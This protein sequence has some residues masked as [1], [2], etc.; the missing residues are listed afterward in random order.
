[1][2]PKGQ[3][4]GS[5]KARKQQLVADAVVV[6][7]PAARSAK[8]VKTVRTEAPASIS[9][10]SFSWSHLLLVIA[11]NAV[12]MSVTLWSHYH[13]PTPRTMTVSSM[14]SPAHFSEVAAL[15]HISVLSDKIGYRIVGTKQHVEAE[16]WLES[17]VKQYEGWHRTAVDG[18]A[19]VD[20]RGDTQVEVWTQIGDGSHR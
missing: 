15:D 8:P 5:K 4:N 10:A 19:T 3:A 9:G 20:P 6:D 14:T 11:F 7:T 2:A 16:E 18:N 1:M 17:I 13:L 12:L